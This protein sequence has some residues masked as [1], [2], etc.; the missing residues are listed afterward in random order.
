[1]FAQ[2]SL[3]K[4][5]TSSIHMFRKHRAVSVSVFKLSGSGIERQINYAVS[6]FFTVKPHPPLLVSDKD[7]V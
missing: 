3:Y 1:V 2:L 7:P 4:G 6:L 5:V